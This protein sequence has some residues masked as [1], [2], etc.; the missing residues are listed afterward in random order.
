MYRP[1]HAVKGS[2]YTNRLAV[3]SQMGDAIAASAPMPETDAGTVDETHSSFKATSR[4]N[5]SVVVEIPEFDASG[6][7]SGARLFDVQL[8]VLGNDDGKIAYDIARINEMKK[9]AHSDLLR[10]KEKGVDIDRASLKRI[11]A[12]NMEVVN[13]G[14]YLQHS[15]S[16]LS[17]NDLFGG[18]AIDNIVRDAQ[19]A[20]AL[21]EGDADAVQK[22]CREYCIKGQ[23]GLSKTSGM[24]RSEYGSFM[25]AHRQVFLFPF[26][27]CY[28]RD[29]VQQKP[30][31][32]RSQVEYEI[33]CG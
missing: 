28:N 21:N 31:Y 27:M 20:S 17:F 14:K 15:I 1:G 26:P 4:A 2:K 13:P 23:Q 32:K 6:K 25:Q 19:Y 11:V 22:G 29:R 10:L 7:L 30:Q 24:L 16:T 8:A 18:S 3:A 9:D 12:E 5:R 33:L